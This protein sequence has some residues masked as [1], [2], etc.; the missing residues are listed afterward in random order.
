MKLKTIITIILIIVLFL[1]IILITNKLL[2][3]NKNDY[4]I[5]I[6][7]EEEINDE[8]ICSILDTDIEIF[9]EY[10]E[11]YI[12]TKNSEKQDFIEKAEDNFKTLETY[13]LNNNPEIALKL[14]NKLNDT[15]NS[16]ATNEFL[17][18]FYSYVLS[19]IINYN[20]KNMYECSN[21]EIERISKKGTKRM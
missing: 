16:F 14:F 21:L 8:K 19:G 5:K 12:G 4:R 3:R 2:N 13:I 20:S 17:N 10:K 1:I 9:K 11:Y 15:D 18:K 7:E 6:I